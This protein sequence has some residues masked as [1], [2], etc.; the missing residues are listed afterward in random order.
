MKQ[1]SIPLGRILGIPLRLDYSWFVIFVLLTW[2]LATSYYPTEFPHW[3]IAQYWLLGAVTAILLFASVVLHELGHS[4]VAR[5]Y[6][7]SVRKITLLVFGGVAEIAAEPPSATAEFWIAIAGPIVSLGLAVLFSLLQ[8]LVA[9]FSPLLALAKYLAVINGSLALF[10]LVPGFPLDGGRV[11]RALVWGAT[12]DLRRATRIAANLGRVIA[13]GF[14]IVGVVQVVNGNFGGLWIIAIGWFLESAASTQILRQRVQD[15]LAGHH[16]ADAMSRSYSTIAPDVPV[17]QVVD[18]YILGH[19]QRY[20]VVERDGLIAGLLTLQHIKALPRATWPT[21][22]VAQAMLSLDQ[23][24]GVGPDAELWAAWEVM[25]RDG[26]S[27]LPVLA[28]NQMLGL[29]SRESII[30]FLRTLQEASR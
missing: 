6:H 24:H 29:L 15:L 30:G 5:H 2:T 12:H 9:A 28:G 19:G 14:M 17:Q 23:M 3:P 16:V 25:D 22:T 20:F 13:F 11:F 26:V 18:R 4:V 1:Q 7:I 21:T 10:N 27:Q 8:P